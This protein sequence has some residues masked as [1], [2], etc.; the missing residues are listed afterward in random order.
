MDISNT[1]S[2]DNYEDSLQ[3]EDTLVV[4]NCRALCDHHLQHS[5]ATTTTTAAPTGVLSKFPI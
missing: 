4:T 2:S 5:A 1:D 3:N